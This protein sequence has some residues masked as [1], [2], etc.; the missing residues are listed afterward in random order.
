MTK[1][2][3]T[4]ILDSEHSTVASEHSTEISKHSTASFDPGVMSSSLGYIKKAASEPGSMRELLCQRPD[5]PDLHRVQ[6]QQP[7]GMLR[8]L[9]VEKEALRWKVKPWLAPPPVRLSGPM[10]YIL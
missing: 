7:S 4:T 6:Q 8:L 10:W 2:R 3:C 9:P 5:L 1:V